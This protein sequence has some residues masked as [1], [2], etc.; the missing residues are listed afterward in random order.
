MKLT[1][2]QFHVYLDAFSWI[3]QEE[4]ED[5][6]QKN[7]RW[8]LKLAAKDPKMKEWKSAEVEKAKRAL[9]NIKKPR[10]V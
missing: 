10:V 3:L 1:W 9:A 7:R 6:R 2:R 5:G 8:D 4:S